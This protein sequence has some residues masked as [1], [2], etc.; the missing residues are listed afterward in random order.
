R[1]KKP[2]LMDSAGM[3]VPNAVGGTPA[4]R[5]AGSVVDP[6][7]G[8]EM[9]ARRPVRIGTAPGADSRP[10]GDRKPR[11]RRRRA[12]DSATVAHRLYREGEYCPLTASPPPE[13]I[14]P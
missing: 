4:R 11:H 5:L 2:S 14:G 12:F 1:E 8:R 6:R 13:E 9:G 10:S 7:I 3:S